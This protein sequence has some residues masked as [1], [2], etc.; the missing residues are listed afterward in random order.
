MESNEERFRKFKEQMDM[1][2]E[3]RRAT[4]QLIDSSLCLSVVGI[5]LGFIPYL[6]WLI[7][8]LCFCYSC[9]A[10]IKTLSSI[11]LLSILICSVSLFVRYVYATTV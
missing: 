5:F 11:S 3:E 1:E 4:N 7:L 10:Y 2:L 8:I 6:G 9:Y